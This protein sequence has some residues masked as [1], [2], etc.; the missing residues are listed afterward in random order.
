MKIIGFEK[1]SMLFNIN[2]IC[3]IVVNLRCN[4]QFHSVLIH[5]ISAS[6]NT[7]YVVYDLN[8]SVM[9]RGFPN[10]HDIPFVSLLYSCFVNTINRSD[11]PSFHSY[12][13]FKKALCNLKR[14]CVELVFHLAHLVYSVC[15][16]LSFFCVT[17]IFQ[18]HSMTQ[19]MTI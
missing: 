12:I 19:T 3:F 2:Y 18:I 13:T 14:K 9:K 1:Y 17:L 15:S 4:R 7:N 11:K 5:W 8:T 16:F 6:T 10:E